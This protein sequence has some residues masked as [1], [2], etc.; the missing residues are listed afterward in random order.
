MPK[1]HL[2]TPTVRVYG[3][4]RS[5]L[6]DICSALDDMTEDKRFN[7]KHAASA[8]KKLR[9]RVL[10]FVDEEVSY[11][12]PS[13]KMT[14]SDLWDY[15]RTEPYNWASDSEDVARLWDRW[16]RV[17]RFLTKRVVEYQ[18]SDMGS[19]SYE[20]LR[21]RYGIYLVTIHETICKTGLPGIAKS[22][23]QKGKK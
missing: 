15:R 10:K 1:K 23:P 17:Y 3:Q 5:E 14:D 6:V 12:D 7:A 21:G 8:V 2:P 18:L 16:C 4:V 9:D 20:K 13:D 22:K 11:L 19:E